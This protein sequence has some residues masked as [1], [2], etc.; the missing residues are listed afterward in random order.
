MFFY[1]SAY[2]IHPEPILYILTRT[3][4][5]LL[6][7][8]GSY[9]RPGLLKVQVYMLLSSLQAWDPLPVHLGELFIGDRFALGIDEREKPV[10]FNFNDS[11]ETPAAVTLDRASALDDDEGQHGQGESTGDE[12]GGAPTCF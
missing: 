6:E 9:G 1:G 2:S 10:I 11:K 8:S 12:K 5:I 4:T 7:H 3:D